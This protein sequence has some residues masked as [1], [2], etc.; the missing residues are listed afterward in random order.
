MFGG[1]KGREGD[2]YN[3]NTKMTKVDYA[4]NTIFIIGLS[5]LGA[6]SSNKLFIYI[7]REK[8]YLN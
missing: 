2:G 1:L 5:S 4:E 7:Y 3:S 6:F 8:L